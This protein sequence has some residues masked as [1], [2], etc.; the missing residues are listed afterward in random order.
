MAENDEV[1]R[2]FVAHSRAARPIKPSSTK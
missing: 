2:A 1:R